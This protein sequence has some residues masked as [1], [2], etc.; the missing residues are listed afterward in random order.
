MSTLP[1]YFFRWPA[2]I[3]SMTI[4]A[5]FFL[6]FTIVY[7]PF[8]L[9]ALLDMERGLFA[10]NISILFAIILVLDSGLRT[11][12]HFFRKAKNFTWA[13][14]I[15]WC[16]GEIILAAIFASLYVSLISAGEY[17]YFEALFRICLPKLFMILIFPY[18]ILSLGFAIAGSAESEE[19]RAAGDESLIRFY[20]AYHKPKLV[21]A[22]KAILYIKADE[23][24]MSIWYSENGRPVK[25][26]LR[27]P[28]N[29]IE[30]SCTRHGLVRCQR[31]YFVNPEHVTILRKQQGWI[32]ADLDMEGVPSIPVSKRYYDKLANLL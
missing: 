24:Y 30:D 26:S 7:D 29:S 12:F 8:G 22:V 10:L 28:M 19:A 3:L 11:A 4:P 23:N 27:A 5:V 31:S 9:V 21:I 14:Y 17:P 6:V 18:V 32:F 15:S 2:V 20:D 25:Y 13:K 1:K 16:I